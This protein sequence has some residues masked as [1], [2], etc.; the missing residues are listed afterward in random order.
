MGIGADA[1]SENQQHSAE[2]APSRFPRAFGESFPV[3]SVE[4]RRPT[5]P[6]AHVVPTIKREGLAPAKKQTLVAAA[7]ARKAATS[8]ASQVF[9]PH[10]PVTSLNS[11]DQHSHSRPVSSR[12][13]T[14]P[15]SHHYTQPL[16]QQ[17]HIAGVDDRVAFDRDQ[18]PAALV[19]ALDH[20]V[21]QVFSTLPLSFYL[22]DY[23]LKCLSW[24]SSHGLW[25]YWTTA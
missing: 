22:T 12:P 13:A 4:S 21:G 25:Q 11:L 24:I 3:S 15:S 10:G 17:S 1:L 9:G 19:G 7:N 18:L 6:P 23:L 2:E 14:A 5:A 16:T 20:I 8:N